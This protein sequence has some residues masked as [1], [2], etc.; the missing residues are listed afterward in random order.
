MSPHS[1]L[2]AHKDRIWTESHKICKVSAQNPQSFTRSSHG[3]FVLTDYG[4]TSQIIQLNKPLSA[5]QP[6]LTNRYQ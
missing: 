4:K 1:L 2:V 6:I 3:V 5:S